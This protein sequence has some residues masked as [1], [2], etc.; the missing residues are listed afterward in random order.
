[1]VGQNLVEVFHG[2]HRQPKFFLPRGLPAPGVTLRALDGGGRG[3][4]F[5]LDDAARG[6]V[7][8]RLEAEDAGRL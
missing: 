7:A 4:L 1:M 6:D 8:W 2:Q 5:E 3:R